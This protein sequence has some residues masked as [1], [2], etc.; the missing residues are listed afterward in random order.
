MWQVRSGHR[1]QVQLGRRL[2][3]Q[4]GGL[5]ITHAGFTLTNLPHR[6]IEEP[7][8]QRNGHFTILIMESGRD[9]NQNMIGIP[10]G[11]LARL[12]LIYL[13]TEAIRTDSPE[14]ALGR[15][16]D[17]WLHRMGIARGG[18]SPLLVTE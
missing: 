18:R 12:I 1:P 4:L 11:S 10:Y 9:R 6:R 8:W 17:A 14:I 16:M 13:Q 15:S 3:Q 7:V 5:G 2:Q